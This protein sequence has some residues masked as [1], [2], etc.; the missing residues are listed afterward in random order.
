MVERIGEGAWVDVAPGIGIWSPLRVRD[1]DLEGYDVAVLVL[2]EPA[3]EHSAGSVS[4]AKLTVTQRPGGPP[5]TLAGI[6][7]IP[8]GGLVRFAAVEE[9]REIERAD[10][11]IRTTARVAP[12]EL[13]DGGPTSTALWWVA[14][15]YRLALVVG[16]PPTK[17]VRDALG[18]SRST[19]GRWVSLAREQGFLGPAEGAGKAG[20]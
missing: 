16:D 1:E 9:A 3:T 4:A 5:V 17:A 13:A 8:V 12:D 10:G 11:V 19:A 2:A 18:L 15:V 6:R 14:Y 7:S 20:G